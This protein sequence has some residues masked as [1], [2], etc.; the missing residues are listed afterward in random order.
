VLSRGKA[1]HSD[2]GLGTQH[3]GLPHPSP[4]LV[5]AALFTVAALFSINYII[6]KLGMRV[7]SPLTFAYLRVVGSALLLTLFLPRTREPLSRDDRR[8]I[9]R[10]AI[11]GV[12]INQALFLAGL[13]LTSAHV[14]AILITG[15]PVFALGIAI[16][17]RTEHATLAKVAGIFLAAMGALLVVGGE[18]ITGDRRSFLGAAMIIGNCLA[19]AAYLVVS[20]PAMLRLGARVVVARMFAIATVVMLPVC[21]WSLLHEHWSTIPPQAWMALVL[22][23]LGPTVAAYMLNAWTLAY[24]ESSLVAAYTY[25]QPFLTAILAALFLHERMHPLVAAAAL[26]IFAGVYLAGRK[27]TD[28]GPPAGGLAPRPHEL[29]ERQTTWGPPADGHGPQR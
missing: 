7:F 28:E 23:I 12:M 1:Q 10:Y 15:I 19:Y 16:A 22:V 26:M 5:H 25:V 14:A 17:M 24:A 11:L 18:G 20:K 27:R 21:G 6:S 9:A 4:L 13:S 8:A 3:S 29:A 2:S